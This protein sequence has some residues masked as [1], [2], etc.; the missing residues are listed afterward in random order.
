MRKL[1]LWL[2][3]ILCAALSAQETMPF[4]VVDHSAVCADGF[5]RL[6][7]TDLT[8]GANPIACFYSINNGAWVEAAPGSMPN[9]EA[10]VPY[11]YGQLLRYRLHTLMEYEGESIAFMNAAYLGADAFPPTLDR[12]GLVGT[13]PTGDSLMVYALPLDLTS[14]YNAITPAKIYISLGNASNAFPTFVSLN[15]YNAYMTMVMNPAGSQEVS[16]ALLY[17]FNIPG[18]ISPGLYKL[19][20]DAEQNPTFTRLGNIQSTVSGGKPYMACN[21]ADLTADPD[22]GAWPNDQ[23]MLALVSAIS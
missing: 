1:I 2:L 14:A 9:S 19:G 3:L 8:G 22:F 21:I 16:Y 10:L 5:M 11:Q 7:W 17:T 13:D 6:Q 20:V 18:L 23:N 15:S 12:M 4:G